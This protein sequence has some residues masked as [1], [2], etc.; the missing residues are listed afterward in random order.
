MRADGFVFNRPLNEALFF[1]GGFFPDGISL[2]QHLN[3]GRVSTVLASLLQTCSKLTLPPSGGCQS[4]KSALLTGSENGV[5]NVG[6][7]LWAMQWF[8]LTLT[9]EATN[10]RSISETSKL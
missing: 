2:G 1:L 3:G 6:E 8:M 5:T 9:R 7:T 10:R 4:I